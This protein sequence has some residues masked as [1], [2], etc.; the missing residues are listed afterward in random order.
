MLAEMHARRERWGH[1]V[2]ICRD[3]PRQRCTYTERHV[4]GGLGKCMHR[5]AGENKRGRHGE[6]EPSTE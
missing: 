3:V 6:R 5:A 2:E 1:T 4:Q